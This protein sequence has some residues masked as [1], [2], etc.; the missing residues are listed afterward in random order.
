VKKVRNGRMKWRIVFDASSHE[1]NAPSLNEVLEMGPNLQ[2]EIFAVLL[3]FRLHHSAIVGDITQAFLQLVLDRRDR[4]LTR[5][6]WYR[7]IPE[8]EGRYR[9][10]NEVIAYRFT[11]LPFG[12]TCSP[13]LLAA[14]LRDH[15]ERHKETFPAVAPLRD[16]NTFMDD[17]AAGAE[18]ENGAIKVYYELSSMMKLINLPLAKCATNAEQLTTIWKAEGQSVEAR[19]QV[20][21]VS[22]NKE[23][24]C[25]YTD[26]NEMTEKLKEGPTTKRKLL[27]TTASFYDPLGLFSPVSLIGKVL[28]QDTW[29]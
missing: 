12:L 17:F 3:Q 26:A 9:T 19:T 2:P 28:F 24:D 16:K 14:T 7:T 18:S 8:G 29:C 11:R 25:L 5:F 10:T 20:L 21:G 13:F 4:D 22:W 23:S 1:S 6:Y 15:A 27:Q